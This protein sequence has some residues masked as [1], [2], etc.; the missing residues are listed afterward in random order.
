MA[1]SYP[2]AA[3]SF[4]AIL[5]GA[6]TMYIAMDHALP[7]CSTIS[8]MIL[9]KSPGVQENHFHFFASLIRN[10]LNMRLFYKQIVAWH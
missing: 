6:W 10:R 5:F 7:I 4:I 8:S 9:V 1:S 3:L 2:K